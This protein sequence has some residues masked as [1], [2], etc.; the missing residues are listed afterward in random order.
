[1]N[2]VASDGKELS[3]NEW[4]QVKSHLMF[5]K[6]NNLSIFN[7]I[8]HLT[9][10]LLYRVCSIAG[11]RWLLIHS[12]KELI[13]TW[14]TTDV[15]IR[16]KNPRLTIFSVQFLLYFPRHLAGCLFGICL[17]NIT[18]E[19]VSTFC[20]SWSF[21]I[22]LSEFMPLNNENTFNVPLFRK[23][24]TSAVDHSLQ[25]SSVKNNCSALPQFFF[26]HS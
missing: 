2:I 24:G 20:L 14:S 8:R 5:F 10:V 19:V 22:S 11:F 25:F 21:S 1:M 17:W 13:L 7:P 6:G 9:R 12:L 4:R 3:N 26:S 15:T 16:F 23:V 18:A